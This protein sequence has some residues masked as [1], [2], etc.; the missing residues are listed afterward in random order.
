MTRPTFQTPKSRQEF[1]D[2]IIDLHKPDEILCE[3]CAKTKTCS[4]PIKIIY[5]CI[6]YLKNEKIPK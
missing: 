2:K 5:S 3:T 4:K 1:I 6:K